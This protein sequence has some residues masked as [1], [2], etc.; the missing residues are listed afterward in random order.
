M[1]ADASVSH[2]LPICAEWSKDPDAIALWDDDDFDKVYKWA[3]AVRGR[4]PNL[5]RLTSGGGQVY[6]MVQILDNS[7]SHTAEKLK[8]SEMVQQKK[9]AYEREHPGDQYDLRMWLC[10]LA[11]RVVERA[12]ED[13]RQEVEEEEDFF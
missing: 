8:Q 2:M 9:E 7:C 1:Y 12:E 13:Y 4:L 11:K 5:K 10:P 3:R 6:K